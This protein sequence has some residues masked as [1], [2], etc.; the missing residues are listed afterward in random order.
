MQ[1]ETGVDALLVQALE[2]QLQ[3]FCTP[4]LVRA[5]EAAADPRVAAQPLWARL[6]ESGLANAALPEHMDGAGIGLEG[7]GAL[8]ELCGGFSL[9]LP[10]GDTML[11]RGYLARAQ[12]MV[13]CGSIA[14]AE[15]STVSLARTADWVLLEEGKEWLLLPA[16]GAVIT[17]AS[18]CLDAQLVW[19]AEQKQVAPRLQ[20]PLPMRSARAMVFSSLL[21]GACMEVFQQTLSF[22]NDR[23]QFGRPIGKFQAIQHQL[24]VLAE[25]AFAAR[26]C[27]Q[28]ACLP[29]GADGLL[30]D[31]Q[32]VAIAKAR[33]SEAA[34][35]IAQLSHSIHGAIGFTRE[36][37]LQLY[38]RRLHAWRQAAGAEGWWHTQIGRSLLEAGNCMAVEFIGTLFQQTK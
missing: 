3:E 28:M 23:Q 14:L 9:P 24:S 7:L 2:A 6:E 1:I 17:P 31:T 30:P 29:A 32:R 18:F 4:S 27:R 5:V 35:E 11:A 34:L 38:T 33:T 19:T 36:F 13:P 12:V 21:A 15:D 37:D 25:H 8:L 10:L 26:M 20:A 16:T 22:A